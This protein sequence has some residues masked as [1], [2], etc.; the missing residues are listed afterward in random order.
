M[1]KEILGK[2]FRKN[3][4]KLPRILIRC[5]LIVVDNIR[6]IFQEF[7]VLEIVVMSVFE[8]IYDSALVV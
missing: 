3:I 1:S 4:L 5:F 8:I 2:E 7:S 6:L